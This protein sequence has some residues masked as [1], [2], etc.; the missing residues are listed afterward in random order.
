MGCMDQGDRKESVML[1]LYKGFDVGHNS[2]SDCLSEIPYVYFKQTGG[3]L[4][5]ISC[6][7]LQQPNSVVCLFF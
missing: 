3:G 6:L 5:L 2:G 7:D 4:P 1:C